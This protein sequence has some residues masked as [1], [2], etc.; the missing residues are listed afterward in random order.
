[1]R[2]WVFELDYHAEW[3]VEHCLPAMVNETV[4]IIR[5]TIVKIIPMKVRRTLAML[6]I[7]FLVGLCAGGCATNYAVTGE[8]GASYGNDGTRYEGWRY[9][10]WRY[11]GWNH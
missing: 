2:C 3:I 1:M 4:Y 6:M 8:D 7:G 10:G 9:G 11:G 5:V